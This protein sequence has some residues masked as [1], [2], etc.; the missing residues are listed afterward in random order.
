MIVKNGRL[1]G[2]TT[3]MFIDI[4]ADDKDVIIRC[5]NP[6]ITQG[7]FTDLFGALIMNNFRDELILVDGRKIKFVAM[8]D[9]TSQIGFTGVLKTDI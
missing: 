9:I 8:S 6:Y 2:H 7:M 3:Q 4:L 1:G 5:R